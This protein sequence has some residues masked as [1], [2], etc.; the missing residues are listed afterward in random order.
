[1]TNQHSPTAAKKSKK[2]G[3]VK[4][5][6]D[7]IKRLKS[8]NDSAS[9]SNSTPVSVSAFGAHDPVLGNNARS[10]EL[11]ASSKYSLHLNIIGIINDNSYL[12]SRWQCYLES[13]YV[14]F[15]SRRSS[16]LN[17]PSRSHRPSPVS[18]TRSAEFRRGS[19]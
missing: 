4:V 2:G 18:E 11:T 1:M 13:E 17:P 5:F 7:L 3:C 8:A 19:R 10:A 15:I 16:G 12:L 6:W 9:H 14:V